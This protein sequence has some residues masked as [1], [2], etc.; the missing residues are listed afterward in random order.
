MNQRGGGKGQ[1]PTF[2][3]VARTTPSRRVS[4]VGGVVGAAEADRPKAARGL[5][6]GVRQTCVFKVKSRHPEPLAP[7]AL[8]QSR[9]KRDRDHPKKQPRPGAFTALPAVGSSAWGWLRFFPWVPACAGTT[10]REKA[11]PP[12]PSPL[13]KQGS[14]FRRGRRLSRFRYRERVMFFPDEAKSFS[15]LGRSCAWARPGPPRQR[16][17][18]PHPNPPRQRGG[19]KKNSL[20]LL[21]PR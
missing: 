7:A 16:R 1:A 3:R 11:I 15:P 18:S 14:I 6:N 8:R 19:C 21:S 12:F 17:G 9:L 2:C 5:V 20:T 10:D 13:R 4:A